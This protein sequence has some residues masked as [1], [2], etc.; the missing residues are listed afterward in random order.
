MQRPA[1]RASEHQVIAHSRELMQMADEL[2]MVS[3]QYVADLLFLVFIAGLAG[4]SDQGK[5]RS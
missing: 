4:S 1:G 5:P 2:V 3:I